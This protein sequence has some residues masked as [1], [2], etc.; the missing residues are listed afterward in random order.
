MGLIMNKNGFTLLELMIVIMII[1]IIAAVAIP[2]I[3]RQNGYNI[4]QPQYSTIPI[5]NLGNVGKLCYDNKSILIIN[6]FPIYEL[7]FDGTPSRC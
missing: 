6:Q 5:G 1:G 2:A 3:T 4:P 7:D